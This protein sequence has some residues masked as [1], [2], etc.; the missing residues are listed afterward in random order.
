MKWVAR[1][2]M[3]KWWF[4]MGSWWF[5]HTDRCQGK[6]PGFTV[7]ILPWNLGVSDVKFSIIQFY[8]VQHS[9]TFSYSSWSTM[10][11]VPYFLTRVKSCQMWGLDRGVF[12]AREG[13]LKLIDFGIAKKLDEGKT[14][15]FTMCLGLPG[16]GGRL[17]QAPRWCFSVN[18]KK[19]T[20][21]T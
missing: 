16:R 5:F 19:T 4:S 3:G 1:K 20:H 2:T 10:M 6:S 12:S 21:G 13:Y 14:R 8:G 7:G 15:T 18:A 11:N 9:G 17:G